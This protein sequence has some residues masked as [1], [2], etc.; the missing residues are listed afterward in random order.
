MME[1]WPQALLFDM[2][3]VLV[4]SLDAWWTALNQALKTFNQQKI[5]RNEFI[6]KYW[7]HDLFDNL[8][9]MGLDQ[10]IGM[11]CNHIYGNYIEKIKI[12]PDTIEILEKL[13]QYKKGVIT[14]TPKDSAHL[15]L[16]HF[17]LARYFDVVVT[18][19]EVTMA[20]PNPEIVF[21]ACTR[22]SVKP[23][24][25]VLIGD[26]DSDVKAGKAA[27]CTVIGVNVEADCTI[28]RLSELT[29][30]LQ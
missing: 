28:Q 21:T 3:G 10:E 8:D 12:Y 1:L 6:A 26:T 15:I 22:L 29:A 24:Q 14:N 25:V 30:I 23:Q 11:L 17:D 9:R 4:D 19:D 5:P 7:G 2:D 16:K 18:S 13:N 27:G 20:K